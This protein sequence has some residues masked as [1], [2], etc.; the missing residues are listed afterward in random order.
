M[1][2]GIVWAQA[3][4]A[5]NFTTAE[6]PTFSRALIKLRAEYPGVIRNAVSATD[7]DYMYQPAGR[8]QIRTA[9]E[10]PVGGNPTHANDEDKV[11]ASNVA[12]YEDDD[13]GYYYTSKVSI[14][15]DSNE[16]DP[17]V[18]GIF[19]PHFLA[20]ELG[21]VEEISNLLSL[22]PS[23]LTNGSR[24]VSG[25]FRVPASQADLD[26]VTDWIQ[27]RQVTTV[28]GDTVQFEYI[29]T[30]T[31]SA[32][33]QVGLRTLIDAT[34]GQSQY[35]GRAII[36]PDKSVITTE[37]TIPSV[38]ST[39][40]LLPD[41]WVAYDN[42]QAPNV[43]LRG[44]LTG[45]EVDNAGIANYAAGPPD[46][47]SFG[48]MRNMGADQ[49]YYFTPNTQASIIDEDWAYAV[50]W[51]PRDLGPGLSR[52][53]VTY[54][55]LGSSAADYTSP[56]AFMAYAPYSLQAGED[57]PATSENE[58]H[59]LVDQD[60]NS[61]FKLAAYMDNFGSS[62]L[63]D[64]SVRVR[65][66][67]GLELAPGE[68]LAKNAGI[69]QR[70]EI[71]NL[72]WKVVAT[73]ARPGHAEVR[74][75]GPRGKVVSRTINIPA[76]PVLNPLPN[77]D[78]GLEMVSVPYE[79]P[80]NDA[81][82]V[83]QSL[84]SLLAG[85]PASLIRYDPQGNQYRWFP[86]P[87]VTAIVPGAGYWLLNRNREPVYMPAGAEPVDSSIA[88][89]VDLLPGWNQIG[90][91]FTTGVRLDEVRVAGQSGGDWSLDEAVARNMLLSTV[92]A[93]DPETNQYTWEATPADTYLDPYMGYWV[94]ARQSCTLMFQPPNQYSPAEAETGAPQP[95][96]AEKDG[97]EF[98]V[99]VGISGLPLVTQSAAVK[100]NAVAGLDRYDVPQPPASIKQ[101]SV[102]LKSAFYSG[103]SALGMPYL[104]DV[105]SAGQERQE[106]NLI[107]KTNAANS[108]AT[109]TW[110]NLSTLPSSLIATLV[111]EAT[112]DRRYMRTTS[113]YTF[114]TG[115]Q[116][117]ERALRIV[118]Q[119][120]G[121]NALAVSSVVATQSA[122][123]GAAISYSL[124]ADAAVD[125]RIRNI[126]GIV[127][128]QVAANRASTA[129]QNT[130]LWSGR[131][132]RGNKVPSGRYLC[133]IVAKSQETGQAVTVVQPLQI[134]R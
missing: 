38:G 120:R 16:A 22:W 5:P 39:N 33:H 62:P 133:E 91:P 93:Y 79:F 8:V 36:L 64:A 59:D 114:R 53:Y 52:R 4:L 57:D 48:Q 128:G 75:T 121:A 9:T 44:V 11:I 131:S 12:Q 117:T 19:D 82:T 28:L 67:V 98:D 23:V 49:Q 122:Q 108:T 110:P 126:S 66:P 10:S 129:G 103:S 13:V 89:N 1:A 24:D 106:W 25:V 30:N 83:F 45:S 90:N 94:L 127:V 50:S 51:Q 107:V 104:M 116:A 47:I 32:T 42:A 115:T 43:V 111:D 46:S 2:L 87:Y 3:R 17:D 71:K 56:Y 100:K 124:S 125:I 76:I 95:K 88:Y 34:F 132:N 40:Q 112:G 134:S 97:W 72:D 130:V 55:G 81:E 109:V 27:V 69:I 18:G 92:Y 35:D 123:G 101:E 41:S 118:V 61:P 20:E 68:S 37:T 84:G 85:G 113:S 65:L 119:P 74:F 58:A 105:R 70:N 29:V 86:D 14:A 78:L 80:D 99:Q 77:A 15:V 6:V 102:Y 96:A 31:T 54:Y 21:F 73:A 7:T 63:Y 60:G 26:E